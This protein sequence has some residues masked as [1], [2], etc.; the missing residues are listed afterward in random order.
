MGI[1]GETF[2]VEEMYPVY[3]NSAEFQEEKDAVRTTHYALEAEKYTPN[4]TRRPRRRPRRERT[5]R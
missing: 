3:K 1:E 2:E 5:L 4:S